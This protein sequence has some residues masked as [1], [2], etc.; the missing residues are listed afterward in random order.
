MFEADWRG[1]YGNLS[2][3]EAAWA[4]P[5]RQALIPGLSRWGTDMPA[6]VTNAS[7]AGPEVLAFIER[8]HA[9]RRIARPEEFAKSALYLAS[10]ASSFTTGSALLADGGVSINRSGARVYS[11]ER[12]WFDLSDGSNRQVDAADKPQALQITQPRAL[13]LKA[14][15]PLGKASV[16]PNKGSRSSRIGRSGR[17]RRASSLLK[18]GEGPVNPA[19]RPA[20]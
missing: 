14:A 20:L 4:T 1:S 19:C 15:D 8:L 18:H 12:L 7:G 9:L 3:R 17:M 2:C 11:I 5:L 10:D 16:T 6:S 13:A